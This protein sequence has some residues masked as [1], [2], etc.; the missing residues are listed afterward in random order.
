MFQGLE[1]V[2]IAARDSKALAEW[3]IRAFGLRIVY[4]DGA[5]PPAYMLQAPNGTVL[6]IL[7][8]NAGEPARY[9]QR[10]LGLRH[11]AFTVTDFDGALAHLREQGVNEFFDR[12]GSEGFSLIFFRDPE[13]NLLHLI[14]RARPLGS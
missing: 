3:Y 14:W 7:P 2:G 6:E 5:S 12:R 10:L 4:E 11:L 13:G 8:A 1:H 9:D